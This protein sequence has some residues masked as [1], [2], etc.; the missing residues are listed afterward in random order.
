[1]RTRVYGVD[2]RIIANA[3]AA[4]YSDDQ[5]AEVMR[6]MY[7]E[8]LHSVLRTKLHVKIWTQPVDEL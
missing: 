6:R 8:L 3:A 5:L 7:P 1:M 4:L 2:Y